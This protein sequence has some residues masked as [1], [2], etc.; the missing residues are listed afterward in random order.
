LEEIEKL[1]KKYII[2]NIEEKINYDEL[3]KM[4]WKLETLE[5]FYQCYKSMIKQQE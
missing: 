3:G 2:N 1:N 4:M 5:N